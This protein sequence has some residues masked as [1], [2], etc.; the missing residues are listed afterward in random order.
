ME[1]KGEIM[2]DFTK[3]ECKKKYS[4]LR[5]ITLDNEIELSYKSYPT[6]VVYT[7]IR[8]GAENVDDIKNL[9]SHTME[10]SK[11]IRNLGPK[12]RRIAEE[13]IE[14]YEEEALL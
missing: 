5:E 6:G 12:R 9:L 2:Y 11:H 1:Y 8:Y 7:F 3:W 4:S 10:K 14:K 13:L